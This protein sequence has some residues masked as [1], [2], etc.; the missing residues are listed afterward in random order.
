MRQP[1]KGR[2]WLIVAAALLLLVSAAS[3]QESRVYRVDYRVRIVPTER[4]AHV[5]VRL[6][7]PDRLLKEVQWRI[8]PERHRDFTAGGGLEVEGDVVRWAPAG[9]ES[10]FKYVFRIEHLRDERSYDARCAESWAIFRGDDLIPPAKVRVSKGAISRSRL[11]LQLPDGWSAVAPYARADNGNFLIDDPHRGFDRPVGWIVVGDLGVVREKVAGARIAVAGPVGQRLHRLDVLALLRWT[12]PS[13]EEMVGALPDRLLVVMAGDPMWRGG[14]S[15]PRSAFVHASRPLI[16]EDGT[17]PVLHEL[18]HSVLRLEPGPG[19]DWIVEGLA[20]LYSMEAL[21]RSRTISRKRHAKVVKRMKER[22][23]QVS[24]LAVD[25][26]SGEIT[27]RGVTVLY[28][29]DA[30]IRS[31]TEDQRGLEDAVGVLVAA[32]PKVTNAELRAAAEQVAGGE[33]SAFFRRQVGQLD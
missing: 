8:D 11:R 10:T 16:S 25:D 17:S 28:A 21:V 30:E 7:D 1:A 12:L 31:R 13:L 19:G 4:V 24:S 9:A 18:V 27:A 26:S 3:A 22:G 6:R 20:E 23:R 5:T 14:L 2:L 32:R 29:L 33:L 15:G